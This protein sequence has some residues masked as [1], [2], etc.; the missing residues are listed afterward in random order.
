VHRFLAATTAGSAANAAHSAA[1]ASTISKTSE[2]YEVP[3]AVVA[4]LVASTLRLQITVAANTFAM[5]LPSVPHSH[6]N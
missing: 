2:V 6:L 5:S 4:L 3:A 1:T